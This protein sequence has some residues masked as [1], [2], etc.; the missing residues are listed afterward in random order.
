MVCE[1]AKWFRGGLKKL[2][3]VI[4]KGGTLISESYMEL[5]YDTICKTNEDSQS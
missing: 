5:K 1:T 2:L 4:M 3:Q